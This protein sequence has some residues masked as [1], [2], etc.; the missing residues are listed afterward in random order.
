MNNPEIYPRGS[1]LFA[2]MEG[3]T[4]P[5]YRSAI[6]KLY[7]EWDY[8]CT[9]F[10]RVPT[11]GHYTQ[12]KLL[13][14]FGEKLFDSQVHKQ[15]TG[16]QILTSYRAQTQQTVEKLQDMGMRHLDLNLGCPS[17]KVNAHL[18]GAYLLAHPE[19]LREI[20]QTIR[21]NFKGNFTVK[22]RTGYKD[23]DLF[24]YL[25]KMFED[26]GVEAITIHGRTRDQLY[27]GVADWEPIR[28]AVQTVSIPVIGN[29]DLWSVDDIMEMFKQTQCHAVML[30]RGA[31]KTPW[32]AQLYQRFKNSP[33]QLNEVYLL[34]ERK[35]SL[36]DYFE[37]LEEE[38]SAIDVNSDAILKRFKSLSRHL[39]DDFD[40]PEQT[41]STFLRSRTLDHFKE[42]L[43]HLH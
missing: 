4:D 2:P 14:H 19:I 9:D 3:V 31:M 18:G 42:H 23:T 26:E 6:Q 38:Y 13:K 39:F 20:I 35:K 1:L 22:M 24:L 25:I 17:K 37:T 40:E 36:Q 28:Q 27:K 41:R 34:E 32:L 10:L 11:Q 16:Y 30:G 15:K 29:G 21:Q 33:G 12:S 8:L 7:P 5:A 43:C